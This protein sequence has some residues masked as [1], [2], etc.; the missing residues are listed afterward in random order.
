MHN[1]YISLLSDLCAKEAIV[2]QWVVWTTSWDFKPG[3]KMMGWCTAHVKK[4]C[5]FVWNHGEKVP[6]IWTSPPEEVSMTTDSTICVC[7]FT[8]IWTLSGILYKLFHESFVVIACMHTILHW[9]THSMWTFLMLILM[10]LNTQDLTEPPV[11]LSSVFMTAVVLYMAHDC[12]AGSHTIKFW[13]CAID[14]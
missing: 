13:C 14:L 11:A 12:H 2:L 9:K 1:N 3:K 8:W 5:C 6:Q 4:G 10:Q 7:S